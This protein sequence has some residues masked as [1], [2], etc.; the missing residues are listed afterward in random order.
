MQDSSTAEQV[1]INNCVDCDH[2]RVFPDPD[3][4][5]WFCDDD[6]KVVCSK[7]RRNITV[8]CR[9]YKTREECSVPV[10]CPLTKEGKPESS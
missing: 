10:W 7:T 2:H 8:A 6:V 3:P 4:H 9:P 5:D 1:K